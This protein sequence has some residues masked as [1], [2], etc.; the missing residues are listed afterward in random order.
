LRK[1]IK[2]LSPINEGNAIVAKKSSD[3][4]FT[5]CMEPPKPAVVRHTV[6]EVVRNGEKCI[7]INNKEYSI[8][9]KIGSGEIIDFHVLY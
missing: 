7:I 6:R 1:D 3:K 9:K 2:P 5:E 8:V 4:L